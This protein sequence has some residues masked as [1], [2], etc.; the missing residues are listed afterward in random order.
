MHSYHTTGL[1]VF[2]YP[3]YL[4]Y[5]LL[6]L[7]LNV[8]NDFFIIRLHLIYTLQTL[9]NCVL[10]SVYTYTY[11]LICCTIKL[12]ALDIIEFYILQL[13]THILVHYSS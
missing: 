8:P 2:Y 10:N 9:I 1:H 11:T 6:L 4:R 13:F 7:H 12:I 3:Y 5:N